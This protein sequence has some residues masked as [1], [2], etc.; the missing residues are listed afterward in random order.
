MSSQEKV[1]STRD[2]PVAI[3]SIA[4]PPANVMS[5]ATLASLQSGFSRALADRDVRAIIVTGEGRFFCAGANINELAALHGSGKAEL[6]SRMGQALCDQIERSPKP[7]IAAI[8]GRAAMGGGVEI[9]L[10]CHLRIVEELTVMASPEVKLGVMVGWG[11][12]QRLPRIV[13]LGRALDLLL[14]GRRITASE[15]LT[16]GLVNR[17]VPN[18]SALD[19]A[20]SM[21]KE[22]S[23]LSAP[24]LAATMDAV[25]TGL[26]KSVEQGMA[27]EA[28]HFAEMAEHDDWVEGT[29]AFMDKRQPEFRGR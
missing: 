16:M 13:G 20:L 28:S 1:V 18:G 7:V 5:Q 8:N 12:S 15:A 21:A 24:V 17:V 10:A 6:F 2:G 9:A 23:A 4:N 3:L 27:R 19:E 22:M 25:L 26:H 11:A 29:S 14:T